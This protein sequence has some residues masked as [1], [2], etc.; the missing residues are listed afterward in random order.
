MTEGDRPG[1]AYRYLTLDAV[2]AL[3]C[4]GCGDCCDSRRTDGY[5]TWAALPADGYADR[6]G[7]TPLI[8]PL[9]RAGDG[10]RDRA[11]RAD[12][13][14]ELSGTR[15]R[16]TAFTPD[17]AGGGACARHDQW[18]PPICAEF[19]AWSPTLAA[20]LAA[21]GEARLE[22]DSLPRCTWYRVIVVPDGDPRVDAAL[23]ANAAR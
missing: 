2:Q 15:F 11:W 6:C 23:P 3:E 4:N 17:A 10:W 22:A 7:G 21:H 16:C 8:I 1:A 20:D 5:W 9:E 13:A 18:R 14:A 19:P 12:D